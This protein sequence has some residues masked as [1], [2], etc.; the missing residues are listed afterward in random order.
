MRHFIL[1][2]TL[3]IYFPQKKHQF[4]SPP[5]FLFTCVT[6][7][8]SVSLCSFLCLSFLFETAGHRGQDGMLCSY[9]VLAPL[10]T[11]CMNLGKSLDLFGF[12][13]P[14]VPCKFNILIYVHSVTFLLRIFGDF[15]LASIRS[16]LLVCPPYFAYDLI[17]LT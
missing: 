6:A 14:Y 15:S 4:L 12:S 5:H 11:G 2:V 13:S 8:K 3:N 9:T 7:L 10:L 1:Q 17:L 16:E